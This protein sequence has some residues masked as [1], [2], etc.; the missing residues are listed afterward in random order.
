M[1]SFHF[2]WRCLWQSHSG[3]DVLNSVSDGV[4]YSSVANGTILRSYGKHINKTVTDIECGF[5]IFFYWRDLPESF[6]E[7]RNLTVTES[8]LLM[9]NSSVQYRTV[10]IYS[11][12]HSFV[13][14]FP[15][16]YFMLFMRNFIYQDYKNKHIIL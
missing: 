12:I 3:R 6:V 15:D 5:Q 7:S 2:N 8:W 11:Y 13:T 9:I 16:S 1:Y 14:F 4:W 10:K